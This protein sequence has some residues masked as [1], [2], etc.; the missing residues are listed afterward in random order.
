[1]EVEDDKRSMTAA[2]TALGK[3]RALFL[4][5]NPHGKSAWKIHH[6]SGHHVSGKSDG[7]SAWKIYVM[8]GKSNG[9]NQW[10]ISGMWKILMENPMEKS[11]AKSKISAENL[12][13]K[14]CGKI[15]GEFCGRFAENLTHGKSV[16]ILWKICRNPFFSFG[17]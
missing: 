8:T 11:I 16:R 7:K 15:G 12:H 14:S 4:W 1:M 6:A 13:G 10:K 9:K 17:D 3:L 5:K 2:S